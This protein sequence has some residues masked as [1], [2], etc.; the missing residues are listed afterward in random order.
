MLTAKKGEINSNT[1]IVGDLNTPLSP[2]DRS[3][4]MKRKKETQAL[5]DTLNEMDLI[6]I[7]STFYSKT[8]DCN[9]F[10]SAHGTFSSIYHIMGHK[11]S[12]GK[13]KNIQIISSIFSDH[14]NMRLDINYRKK[15]VKIQKHGG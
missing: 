12:L 8:A 15:S 2:M 5:N 11:S 10:T 7:Y 14:K 13:C 1:I 3:C 9:F 4:K 6:H